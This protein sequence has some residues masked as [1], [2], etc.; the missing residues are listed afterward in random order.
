MLLG[1]G[2]PLTVRLDLDLGAQR[3]RSSNAAISLAAW[4]GRAK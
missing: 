2:K 3:P 4:V 1:S